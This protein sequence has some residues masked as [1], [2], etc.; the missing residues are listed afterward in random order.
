MNHASDC[1][2]IHH[3]DSLSAVDSFN[4]KLALDME[5]VVS[6]MLTHSIHTDNY[7]TVNK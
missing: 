5:T 1:I 7:G 6:G 2:F 4:A 3:Q